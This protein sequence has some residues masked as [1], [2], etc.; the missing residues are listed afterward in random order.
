MTAIDIFLDRIEPN[1]LVIGTNNAGDIPL[2]TTFTELVKIQIDL[3]SGVSTSTALWSEPIN[4]RLVDSIIFRK[5]VQLIPRGWSAGL[6]LEGSG[7]ETIANALKDK[8]IGE[9][10]H[11]RVRSTT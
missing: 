8:K 9:F 6:R 10:I 7:I 1:G 4:L 5:S 3:T 2:E 11:L